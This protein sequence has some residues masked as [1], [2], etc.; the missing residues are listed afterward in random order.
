MLRPPPTRAPT[1]RGLTDGE[2]LAKLKREYHA[3]NPS[4]NT[5]MSRIEGL[6]RIAERKR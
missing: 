4:V 3:P 1:L 6:G 2:Y 5:K